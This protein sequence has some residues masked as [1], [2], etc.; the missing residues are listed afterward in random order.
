[1]RC[2]ICIIGFGPFGSHAVNASW[3]AVQELERMGLSNDVQL[4]TKEIAVEYGTVSETVP[5]L[6]QQYQPKVCM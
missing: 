4:I 1:M 2:Y 5:K 3:V 6:W